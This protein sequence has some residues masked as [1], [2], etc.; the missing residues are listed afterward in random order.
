MASQPRKWTCLYVS[1]TRE[2]KKQERKKKKRSGCRDCYPV[3][4]QEEKK[5]YT[6][7]LQSHTLFVPL[8]CAILGI[9]R[10]PQ[11]REIPR[12][13]LIG[14]RKETQKERERDP[15]PVSIGKEP[16]SENKA[17]DF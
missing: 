8:L 17:K 9:M 3:T 7:S 15:G 10:H 1:I 13:R 5:T 4:E 14:R 16:A 12:S 6:H 11:S 2:G